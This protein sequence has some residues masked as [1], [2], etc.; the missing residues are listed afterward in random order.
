MA[1]WGLTRTVRGEYGKYG[2]T[3]V[4]GRFKI[5]WERR[6]G[7]RDV[8]VV[9][10]TKTRKSLR[11]DNLGEVRESVSEVMRDELRAEFPTP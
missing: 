8:W 7:A 6:Q 4:L 11:A 5:N 3:A 9:F 10:D 2:Y 1:A